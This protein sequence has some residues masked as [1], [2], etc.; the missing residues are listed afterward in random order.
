MGYL[1]PESSDLSALYIAQAVFTSGT[2]WSGRQTQLLA[3]S[4]GFIG[5]YLGFFALAT[6][7]SFFMP[8]GI[9]NALYSFGLLRSVTL[10]NFVTIYY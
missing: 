1:K 3:N 7:T 5:R 10:S 2:A 9:L 4:P 6:G 8:Q